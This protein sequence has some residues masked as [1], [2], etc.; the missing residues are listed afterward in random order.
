MLNIR[1]ICVFRLYGLVSF[2]IYYSPQ[3][4]LH[5]SVQLRRS[6]YP[7][8]YHYYYKHTIWLNTVRRVIAYDALYKAQVYTMNMTLAH[9]K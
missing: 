2:K 6:I 1:G 7:G 3:E 4:R 9:S 8:I 5:T